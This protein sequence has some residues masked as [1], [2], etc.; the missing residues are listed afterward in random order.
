MIISFLM[1]FINLKLP[2]SF[3]SIPKPHPFWV[4][5]AVVSLQGEGDPQTA[6]ELLSD[7]QDISKAT[8]GDV[9]FERKL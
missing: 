8:C 6:K 4:K 2:Q 5:G 9:I 7:T 1:E 3:A